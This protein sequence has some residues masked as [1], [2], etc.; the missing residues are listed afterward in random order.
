MKNFIKRLTFISFLLIP[1]AGC[2]PTKTIEKKSQESITVSTHKLSAYLQESITINSATAVKEY[3]QSAL[4]EPGDVEPLYSLGYAHMQ[5]GV[6][7][8]TKRELELAEIYLNEVLTKLPGNRAVLTALYNVYY[9]SVIR[10]YNNQAF[11]KAKAIF[12]QMPESTRATTNPPSLAKF[13]AVAIQQEKDRQLNM[14][15][16]R[17][18]LLQAIQESPL[19]DTPYLHLAK[20]YRD[21]RYFS[22]ALATLKLGEEN[23]HTSSELYKAIADTYVKRAEVNGCSYEHTSDIANAAKYYQLAI[24]LKPDDQI[25]HA[26]L[27]ESFLDQNFNQLGLNEAKIAF[28]LKASNESLGLYAQSLSTV[29]YNSQAIEFLRQAKAEGYGE[30]RAGY[31]EIYMNMGDWKN[32]AVA[33]EAY[34]KGRE[35]FSVYDM[36]K[37]DLIAQHNNEKS[38]LPAA[39]VIANNKWEQALFSYWNELTTAEDLKKMA[40]TKCEKTEYYFYSGYKD[41]QAGKTAQAHRKFAEAINQNT[42]RFI[43]RPLAR[44]F[45]QH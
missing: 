44:Y 16:L 43:E 39:K 45:L 11:D 31:H 14:E 38:L 7:N 19:T 10:D 21:D 2:A 40:L 12:K 37:S 33:F 13:V 9:E 18:I 3:V 24:P 5:S 23:I 36:I 30:E 27:S 15:A 32:A 28:E 35:Q 25:L 8:K 34:T 17:D 26:A 29:G 4:K 20:I 42:Y 1:V 41:F 22:L 6:T